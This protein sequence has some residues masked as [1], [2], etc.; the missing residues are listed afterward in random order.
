MAADE[1]D[2]DNLRT[3]SDQLGARVRRICVVMIGLLIIVTVTITNALE[4]ID[5]RDLHEEL[6]KVSQSADSAWF[7]YDSLHSKD[8]QSPVKSEDKKKEEDKLR[9]TWKDANDKKIEVQRKYDALLKESFSIRPSL[10]GSNLSLDLRVWIYT[11]PFIAI[12]AVLYVSILRKKQ[13]VLLILAAP[14][15][16]DLSQTGTLNRLAFSKSSK[17]RTAYSR[18]PSD[19]EQFI[20]VLVT[21]FL[22]TQIVSAAADAEVISLGLGFAES[23]QYLSMFLT[24]VFYAFGYYFFTSEK[25]DRQVTV[26]TQKVLKQSIAVRIWRKLGVRALGLL[27]RLRPRISLTTGSLLVLASLFLSTAASCQTS[28]LIERKPG[29]TLL[30]SPG[31]PLVELN[32]YIQKLERILKSHESEPE[33]T[34]WHDPGGGWWISTIVQ[35][36][37]MGLYWQN[38]IHN[39]GRCAYLLGVIVAIV[40]IVLV[41]TSFLERFRSLLSSLQR[42]LFAFSITLSLIVIVDFSFS[43]YWFKD[44][45][46]LLS[47]LLWV[48]PAA[49]L[50]RTVLSKRIRSRRQSIINKEILSVVLTPLA[51]SATVYVGYVTAR[52]FFGVLAYFIGINLLSVTYVSI[53]NSQKKTH[54]PK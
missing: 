39:L 44:E 42:V 17:L 51:L 19:L 16:R 34:S 11:L 28:E 18:T 3:E 36:K 12:L 52:G 41:L 26:I 38:A 49:I 10:L 2:L 37:D 40:T 4:K 24:T 53:L 32:W 23:L 15:V 6:V 13:R 35:P 20:Y 45:L 8:D 1:K 5:V 9:E 46:F 50:I 48:V 21:V 25:I 22:L 29:Y 27:R 14:Q 47:N 7:I 30:K 54:S 43:T 31:G 33:E